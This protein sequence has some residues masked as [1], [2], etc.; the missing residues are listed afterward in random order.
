[1]GT[2][3]R[4]K[5]WARRHLKKGN[6]WDDTEHIGEDDEW[7]IGYWNSRNHSHRPFLI[8]KI[9]TL[10][11]FNSVLEIGCNCGPNLYLMSKRFPGIEITGIDINPRAVEKG[12]EWFNSEG[13]SNVKLSV[14]KADRLEQ[15][16]DKSFDIVFTDAVLIYI[17]PD[18][19]N[20]VM[21]GMLRIARRA[22][23]LLERHR[24]KPDGKD[25]RGLGVY[26]QGLW[27]RDYVALLKQFVPE[28]KI[29]VT[30]I[31]EEIWPGWKDAGTVIEVVLG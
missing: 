25:P 30:K 6:D 5:E 1:M 29:H 7:I 22:L 11:P 16:P 19:I 14:G 2:Q 12:N 17:G 20:E 4:E 24:S 15:F 26:S 3:A 23:V 9:S 18:K 31:P 10:C 8:E 13:I 21:K 28:D 27:T